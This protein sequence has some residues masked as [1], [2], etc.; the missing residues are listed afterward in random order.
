MISL[1]WAFSVI[2]K[3]REGSLTAQGRSGGDQCLWSCWW[4]CDNAAGDQDKLGQASPHQLLFAFHFT[5]QSAHNRS[6]SILIIKWAWCLQN[7][8]ATDLILP[9]LFLTSLD[10]ERGNFFVYFGHYHY[11]EVTNIQPLYSIPDISL[12]LWTQ[13]KLFHI[14]NFFWITLQ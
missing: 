7:T 10:E 2:V 1:I 13:S 9:S 3:L 14:P 5:R 12:S 6:L 8:M 4:C 11:F